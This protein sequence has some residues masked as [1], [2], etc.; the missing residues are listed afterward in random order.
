MGL[1]VAELTLYAEEN[2]EGLKVLIQGNDMAEY[3]SERSL[4]EKSEN[5]F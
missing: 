2:R 1:F 4:P 5:G 3:T